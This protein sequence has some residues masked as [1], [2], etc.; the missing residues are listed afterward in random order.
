MNKMFFVFAFFTVVALIIS[1]CGPAA[2]T[3]PLATEAPVS[4]QPPQPSPTTAAPVPT[5]PPPTPTEGA[6]RIFKYVYTAGPI[7]WDPSASFSTEAI[8]LGNMY[9]TLLMVNP[10]GSAEPYK[11]MLAESWEHSEDGL[12]WTFHLR[13]GV[14]FQDGSDLNADAVIKSLDRT[15]NLGIGAGYIWAPVDTMEAPDPMTVVF[16]L[17]YAAHLELIAGSM[18]GSWIMSPKAIEAAVND[19][20]Y[21]EQG[22]GVNAGTGPYKLESYTPEKEVVLT[23][24]DDYWGGWADE[25]HND[26][27][28]IYIVPDEVTRQQM[29]MGGEVDQAWMLP[30]ETI[31]RLKDDP[32][33]NFY[34]V[35]SPYNYLAYL[36]TQKPP[37]DNKLVRQA[38]AYAMP[39]ADILEAGYYGYGEQSHSIVPKGIWPYSD[40]VFQYTYDVEKAKELMKEAGLEGQTIKLVMTYAVEMPDPQRYAPVIKDALAAIGFDVEI[41]PLM[42]AQ[43]WEL[44]KSEDPL[45]RQD[46]LLS[47]Y[48]PTYSDGGV[49]NLYTMLH[50]EVG[51]VYWNMSGWCNSEFDKLIG[52]AALL[53]VTDPEKSQELYIQ[54]MDLAADES[55]MLAFY[56]KNFIWVAPK[57]IVA[58]PYN[59]NYPGIVFF[60]S[61]YKK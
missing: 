26:K 49:D 2:T 38:I 55:P 7:T 48:W 16:T 4:T 21:F 13:Q 14:K 44:A 34:E 56:D 36:N 15:I 28:I 37:L 17:K 3:P 43:Q 6:L 52:D 19:P 46:I 39:Y 61:I 42:W 23:K 59:I 11:P 22:P 50:C 32:N 20:A 8:Y 33:Y 1:A 9:E 41:R 54:A 5:Q 25:P 58:A 12:T 60:Y 29:L 18:F 57:N 40:K 27:V 53:T 31:L 47:L 35:E 30:I 45:K 24:F 51:Y 10:P